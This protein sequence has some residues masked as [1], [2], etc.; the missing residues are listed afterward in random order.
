MILSGRLDTYFSK[1]NGNNLSEPFKDLIL[2]LF[3]YDGSQ[4]PSI[5]Q[6]RSHPWMNDP[7][8]S[9]DGTRDQLINELMRKRESQ[10]TANSQA[11]AMACSPNKAMGSPSPAKAS[12]FTIAANSVQ[13]G[14]AASRGSRTNSRTRM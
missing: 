10:Q 12:R 4:R 14:T 6:L 2:R 8:Y 5:E 13:K 11:A 3:S 9:H 1:V 7:A